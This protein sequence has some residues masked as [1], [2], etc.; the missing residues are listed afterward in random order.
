MSSVSRSL[1]RVAVT[2]DEPSLVADAGLIVPATLMVRLGLERLVNQLVRL[3][4][5]VGGALPGRKV[6]TLVTSILAGGPTSTTPTACGPGR[7]S[8]CFPSR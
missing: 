5:R 8:G 7:P 2:F 3:G 4:G 1:D 6:L